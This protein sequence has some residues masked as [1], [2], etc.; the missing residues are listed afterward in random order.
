M[1]R[2]MRHRALLGIVAAVGIASSAQA[3]ALRD[4]TRPPASSARAAGKVEPSGWTL[5]SVLISP[6]RRYAIINGEVVA[7][8]GS[9]G[10]AVLVAVA[11]ERVTLRTHDGLRTVPLY[12]DLVRPGSDAASVV[13]KQSKAEKPAGNKN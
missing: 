5:Q 9:V 1:A 13:V 3:Q 4:P 12:P 11:P 10:G 6:E 7:I 2:R 8:G